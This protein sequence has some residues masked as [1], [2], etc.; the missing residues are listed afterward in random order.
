MTLGTLLTLFVVPVVY[1]LIG[2]VHHTPH[3][4]IAPGIVHTPAE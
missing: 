1:S 3:A 2:R 4:E